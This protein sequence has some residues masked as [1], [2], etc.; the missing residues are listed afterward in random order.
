MRP[1]AGPNDFLTATKSTPTVATPQSASGRRTLHEL[2]PS[3]RTDRPMSIVASGGLSTVM[4]LFASKLP[5]NQADQ[6]WEPASA[7]AE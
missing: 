3:S 7:A 4:K 5:K 2:S 6:L 1:A